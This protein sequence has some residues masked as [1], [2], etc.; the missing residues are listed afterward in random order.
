MGPATLHY[1]AL[2][3]SFAALLWIGRDQ[4]F[5]G[6]DWA[7]LVPSNDGALL[8][9]HMGHWNLVPAL[10]FPLVRNW[11]GLG[12]YLPFLALA[13][14]MHL[15]VAHLG[16]RI[17]RRIGVN[18]WVAV[19]LSI[20]VML[21]GAAAENLMWA[22]QFG[23]MGA[24]AFGLAVVLLFD[25]PKLT[26]PIALA[27]I[28]CSVLAPMFSGTAIPVLVAAAVVGWIRHGFLRTAAL[29]A[30][31]FLVYL[32]WYF[33]VARQH[34][35]PNTGIE[36]VADIGMVLLFAAAMFAGGLGRIFSPIFLGVIPAVIAAAWF[37]VTVRRGILTAAA[38]AYA[39]AIGSVVFVALTSYSR[40]S[41]GLS[42]AAAQRYA[43]VTIV[44]LVPAFGIML[45]WLGLR[46]RAFLVSVLVFIMLMVATNTVMLV[47]GAA[48]QAEREASSR[49]TIEL[50]LDAIATSPVDPELLNAMSEPEWAP[51]V[52]WSD[53]VW[54][55]E[56]GQLAPDSR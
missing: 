28:G 7:I 55:F 49:A 27:I 20:F 48:F 43:Y 51:D 36:S 14:I 6:D 45:T 52:R 46:G 23:F 50:A 32:S 19:A 25:Q 12:S 16:W 40:A 53:L 31:T 15:L 37:Y 13:V 5:F 10:V 42:A 44:L 21:L 1:A 35:V 3:V 2:V 38:P 18:E 8:A 34:P 11:L 30:P 9:P 24:I 39:L 4:W 47:R 54:L 56:A 41:Y 17:L 33:L 29:M 26:W 22:F